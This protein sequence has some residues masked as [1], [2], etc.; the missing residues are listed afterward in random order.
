M[1]F[2][3]GDIIGL[4]AT[5]LG[6][7]LGTRIIQPRD[8]DRAAALDAIARGAA[9]LML[10]LNPQK[11]WAELLSLTVDAISRAAGLP[12]RNRDA[13]ERAAAAALVSLRVPNP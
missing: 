3:L 7:W 5:V 1:H 2:S 11:K 10:S 12:T 4:V 13:I 9:A 6:G 8:H